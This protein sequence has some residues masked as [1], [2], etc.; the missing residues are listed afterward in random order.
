M[1]SCESA[2]SAK[3]PLADSPNCSVGKVA[4]LPRR[5][6]KGKKPLARAHPQ[7]V[8]MLPQDVDISDGLY[9]GYIRWVQ[10]TILVTVECRY[11]YHTETEPEY[12]VLVSQQR[13]NPE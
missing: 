4:H 2:V 12:S 11:F 13:A 9:F 5:E 7:G 10:V 8:L 1:L 6:I 3:M